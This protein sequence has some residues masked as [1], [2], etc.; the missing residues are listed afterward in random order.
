MLVINKLRAATP[1]LSEILKP[2]ILS[3][4]LDALFPRYDRPNPVDDWS[5]FM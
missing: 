5:G 2:N 1:N 3:G 4:L